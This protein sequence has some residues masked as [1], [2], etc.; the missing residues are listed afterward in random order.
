MLKKNILLPGCDSWLDRNYFFDF[1]DNEDYEYCTFVERLE[2]HPFLLTQEERRWWFLQIKSF[3][4]ES[5][6]KRI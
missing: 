5:E 2:N 4:K 3:V 6:L 1:F